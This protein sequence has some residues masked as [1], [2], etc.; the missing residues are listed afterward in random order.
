MCRFRGR[1]SV[2]TRYLNLR[3][4]YSTAKI[5]CLLYTS[6]LSRSYF[7]INFFIINLF[8]FLSDSMLLLFSLLFANFYF[9]GFI[10]LVY[11][12]ISFSYFTFCTF[13]SR[14]LYRHLSTRCHW[15]GI[16]DRTPP[17]GFNFIYLF[18]AGLNLYGQ[19]LA[20]SFFRHV[21]DVGGSNKSVGSVEIQSS[22]DYPYPLSISPV[23]LPTELM[24]PS[25]FYHIR[26]CH[27]LVYCL[28]FEPKTRIA[29]VGALNIELMDWHQPRNPLA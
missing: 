23:R 15:L 1:Q 12:I 26:W 20:R 10:F 3:F 28:K 2:V 25:R 5:E 21:Q 6:V 7:I 11:F 17:L 9:L 14:W 18:S 22:I 27:N 24:R 16:V 13:F 19:H 4:Y 8:F 29:R